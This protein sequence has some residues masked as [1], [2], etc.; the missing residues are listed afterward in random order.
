VSKCCLAE[1]EIHKI[2]FLHRLWN[3][4]SISYL[5]AS[6]GQN[7]KTNLTSINFIK[8]SCNQTSMVTKEGYFVAKESNLCNE[9]PKLKNFF[10]C[11]L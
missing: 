5:V 10:V 9:G 3:T 7:F 6:G 8:A 4:K 1:S 2:L 11:N